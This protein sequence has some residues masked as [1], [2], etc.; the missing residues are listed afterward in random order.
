MNIQ[1]VATPVRKSIDVKASPARAFEVFTAQMTKW[2]HPDHHIGKAAMK[3]AVVEPRAGGRWYEIGEDGAECEWGKVLVW[4]PPN[5]V[6]FAWQLNGAWQY[7]P[8]FV[9][10]VEV[11]FIPQGNGTRVELEHRNLDRFGDKA[12]E[13]RATL[14]SSDGWQSGLETYARIASGAV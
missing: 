10:E 1:I 12:V 13:V 8:D 6:V 11:R 7:D 4:E 3:A 14:D 9:T 5:R 2:W